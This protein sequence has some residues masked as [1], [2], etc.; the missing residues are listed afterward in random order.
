MPG[1]LPAGG[2]L[3]IVLHDVGSMPYFSVSLVRPASCSG[4]TE[5]DRLHALRMC[6]HGH[7]F[8]IVDTPPPET[9]I[10]RIRTYIDRYIKICMARKS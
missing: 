1:P 9:D 3:S 7:G 5:A 4:G 8:R 2:R 6:P 10:S